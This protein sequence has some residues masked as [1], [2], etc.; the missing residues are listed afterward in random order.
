MKEKSRLAAPNTRELT[1][2]NGMVVTIHAVPT[3]QIMGLVPR[4]KPKRPMIAMPLATG[5]VQMR[6]SKD[7]DSEYFE[8]QEALEAW[9]TDR[10]QL[11]R[12]VIQVLAFGD[13]YEYPDPITLPAGIQRLIDTGLKP[14]PVGE[15]AIKAAWLRSYILTGLQDEMDV[16]LALQEM[17]GVPL[18]VLDEIKANFRNNLRRTGT[19]R[20]AEDIT[21]PQSV[22]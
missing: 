6:P 15:W 13:G 18:E 22:N 9:E 7:G 19:E 14:A 10:G 2:T 8:Y 17:S 16:D 1:L 11:Q 5:Q 4:P 12:D 3:S 21:E 20:V